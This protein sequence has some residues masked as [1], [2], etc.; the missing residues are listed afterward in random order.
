MS[1][2]LSV[3]R[4]YSIAQFNNIKPADEITI[5]DELQ[6]NTEFINKVRFL[7]FIN[8]ELH[9]RVYLKLMEKL[10]PYNIDDAIAILEE[11]KISTMED[12]NNILKGDNK[13][14]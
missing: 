4:T 12:I 8:L 6:F 14:D 11:I 7:Q 1:R 10:N 13:N 2:K 3:E 5:P 9:Y